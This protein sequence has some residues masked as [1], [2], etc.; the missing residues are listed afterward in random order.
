MHG[1]IHFRYIEGST[2]ETTRRTRD[3]AATRVYNLRS[4]AR[5]PS[6]KVIVTATTNKVQL[7]DLI[8]E[9]ITAHKGEFKTHTLFITGSDPIPLEISG[10]SV[11]KRLDMSTTQEEGDTLIV[12]QVA[13]I[14]DGTVLVIADDTDIFILLLHFCNLDK[15]TCGVL[16]VSPVQGR[17]VLDV[18]ASIE[19]HSP[20]IPDL[21]A[22]HGLTGCD[23]VASYFGIGKGV[24]LKIVKSGKYPLNLL[25]NTQTHVPFSDVLK[26]A[27]QFM[28]ACYGQTKCATLTEARKKS[29]SLKVGKS[30][31]S[32][33][34]LCSL[35]PTSE[36]F[37][38]NVGRAHRQVAIWRHALDMNPP[39][40]N[41]TD[42]G[43]SK[44]NGSTSLS[45][46]TVQAGVSLAPTE[47]LKLIRCSCQSHS[48]CQTNR[49]S[50]KNSGMACT[51]FCYCEGT[52][53]CQNE[54]SR[55]VLNYNDD[56]ED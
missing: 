12:Q 42:Y 4:T 48:P 38:E 14:A 8:V 6:Q 26:Q 31:A 37:R 35:P 45:P 29:W 30:K 28:L 24:A 51:V 21:L 50:C 10:G 11:F 25:G 16:M 9:D 55:E 7:I 3:R 19:R 18:S 2:K 43:W 49:C 15:I 46:T 1:L 44:D 56:E 47:L 17:V 23:T 41:P 39:N 36:A 27:T 53:I 52:D 20:I 32:A 33:P 22:A 5:L 54:K 40:L 34:K 13:L